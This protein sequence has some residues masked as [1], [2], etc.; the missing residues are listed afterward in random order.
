MAWNFVFVHFL[1]KTLECVLL[2]WWFDGINV[3]PLFFSFLVKKKLCDL[4]WGQSSQRTMESRDGKSLKE[5]RHK[6]STFP[7][8]T[9][10]SFQSS[11]TLSCCSLGLFYLFFFFLFYYTTGCC[12]YTRLYL[13]M[14]I[15]YVFI[16]PQ[17]SPWLLNASWGPYAVAFLFQKITLLML[18]M[19]RYVPVSLYFFF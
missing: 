7:S 4:N 17:P 19:C 3:I 15:F 8:S 6:Y 5:A 1:G 14:F 16:K 2:Y 10:R 13:H 11:L 18:F 12:K 9:R